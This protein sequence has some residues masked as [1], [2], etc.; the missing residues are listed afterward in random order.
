MW[1]LNNGAV[2]LVQS[3]LSTNEK[4]DVCRGLFAF[5]VV[6]AHA[7]EVAGSMDPAARARLEAPVSVL[8]QGAGTG[9]YWVMGFFVI[10]GYCIQLS[11][12][13]L[14]GRGEFPAGVYFAAR[15]SRLLPLYYLALAF[16]VAVEYGIAPARP[17]NWPNGLSGRALLIQNFTQ[18]FGA[19]APSWSITNEA[20]YYAFYGVLVLAL[21]GSRL[22]PERIGLGVCVI[23]GWALYLVYRFVLKV[24]AIG[25]TSM[26]FALG[27]HWF[28]GA[29]IAAHRTFLAGNR[30]IQA[31]AR[32]WPL[33]LGAAIGMKALDLARFEVVLI[34][35]GVAFAL[36]LIRFLGQDARAGAAGTAPE[37][38]PVAR[39]ICAALGLASYPTYLF[40][41]PVIMLVGSILIRL[42]SPVDWSWIVVLMSAAGIGGGIAGGY[43]LEAPIMAWRSTWL[44]RLAATCGRGRPHERVGS[45]ARPALAAGIKELRS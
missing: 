30:L 24:P 45:F 31:G 1:Q 44:K 43:L 41:G 35:S 34:S 8:I 9:I 22:R 32:A 2:G 27:T 3:R 26:L 40:H 25:A 5:L 4:I 19:F 6:L 21:A 7:L 15:A 11:V 36:M 29:I 10:S 12:D 18:T 33:V 37:T 17:A 16:A 20:F 14:R 13:R 42:G 38:Q 39:S 23:V 28:L